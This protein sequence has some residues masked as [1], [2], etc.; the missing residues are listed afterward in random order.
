MAGSAAGCS[1]QIGSRWTMPASTRRD[2]NVL[3]SSQES[4]LRRIS[5]GDESSLRPEPTGA[6]SPRTALD[7]RTTALARLASVIA[8]DSALPAYQ[9]GVQ[10]ALDAGASVDEIVALLVVLAQPVG[11]SAIITAAPKLAMALGYD[12]EAGLEEF[13]P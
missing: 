7:E 11:T 8:R 4:L 3:S 2:G 1:W 6:A 12:V 5:I 10:A 9:R 13:A